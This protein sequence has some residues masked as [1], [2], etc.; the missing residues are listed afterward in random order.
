MS[1]QNTCSTHP[2]RNPHN[3]IGSLLIHVLHSNQMSSQV[4]ALCSPMAPD[5][6]EKPNFMAGQ[7]ICSNHH[8][9]IP[10]NIVSSLLIHL[11][12]I[13]Q[14]SRQITA[15]GENLKAAFVFG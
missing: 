2:A 1:G 11:V 3:V 6:V 14:V 15:R 5:S 13:N 9:H 10:H 12:H 8:A 4:T 7:R